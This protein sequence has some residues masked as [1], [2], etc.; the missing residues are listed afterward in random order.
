VAAGLDLSQLHPSAP[1]WL[2]LS[3]FD[4]RAAWDGTWPQSGQSLH[5]EAASWHG[6]PVFFS[7]TGPWSR[8][9]RTPTDASKSENIG[10][11]IALIV[12]LLT[13]AVGV[14]FA[15]RNLARGRGDRQNAWRLACIAFG[16]GIVTFL[17]RLHFVASLGMIL[18]VILAISTSL[19]MAGTLWV[20]YVALEPYVRRNWPQTIISWTRLMSGRVRDPLVG[21]DL[22]FGI[23]MGI[24][25]IVVFEVGLLVRM[26][27]GSPP[28][29]PSNDYLMGMREAA[30]AL[31]SILVTSILGTLLFFLA[32]VV[33]RILVRN[34]WVAAA[35]F[36]A[37]FTIPKILGSNHV[38]VDTLVWATIYA[39]AAIGCVRFGLIVLGVSSLMANIL[40]NLPYTLDF[41]N[42]Y[43]TQCFFI[44]LIF[45]A[46]GAWGVYT[47]LA[48]RPLWKDD[49]L[50]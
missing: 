27:A 6:R 18:L 46:I 7:L 31:S 14:W 41:S 15:L 34:A 37:I 10:N 30:G 1:R 9:N 4:T 28:E 21:R 32:L 36:V 38:V 44:T 25:W 2:S 11:I 50:D 8:P 5:V 17:V 48:G 12:A 20:L 39:I 33:L 22:V 29:F 19:F 40:L 16:I 26:R 23:M 24:S 3:A 43:A 35:L 49:L 13:I 45:V 42:W 47:S